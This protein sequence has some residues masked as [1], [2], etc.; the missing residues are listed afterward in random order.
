MM[1]LARCV[2]E[3]GQ[4]EPQAPEQRK[5]H[6]HIA[7]A[8]QYEVA[9]VQGPACCIIMEDCTRAGTLPLCWTR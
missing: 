8:Q 5:E 3:R 7:C 2:R 1:G 9:T 6:M 4:T